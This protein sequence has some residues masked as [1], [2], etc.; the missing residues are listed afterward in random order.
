[1]DTPNVHATLNAPRNPTTRSRT[2]AFARA[3]GEDKGRGRTA[4]PSG[5]WV[6]EKRR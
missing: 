6:I 2:L 4:H 3:L 1:M 5:R